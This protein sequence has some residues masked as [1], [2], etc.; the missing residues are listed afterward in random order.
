MSSMATDNHFWESD[1]LNTNTNVILFESVPLKNYQLCGHLFFG[2]PRL[3][4]Y[5][6]VETAE[7]MNN[8]N[9]FSDH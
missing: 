7:L 4:L 3:N 6:K 9:Q 2:K 5:R 1:K 8:Y